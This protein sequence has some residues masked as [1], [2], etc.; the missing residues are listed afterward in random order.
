MSVLT[1]KLSR[2]SAQEL[3]DLL[4]PKRPKMRKVLK[5]V[6]FDG[7]TYEAAG[8]ECGMSKQAIYCHLSSME[9]KHENRN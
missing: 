7:L 6:I 5:K 8:N 3:D 4:R 2:L 1:A 9:T